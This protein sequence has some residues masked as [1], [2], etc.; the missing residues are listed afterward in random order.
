MSGFTTYRSLVDG[1]P[2]LTGGVPSGVIAMSSESEPPDGWTE[3]DGGG[4]TLDMRD[5]YIY[6]TNDEAEIGEQFGA[7]SA[8]SDGHA[9]EIFS[10]D[11]TGV[12]DGANSRS[13][14]TTPTNS[15]SLTVDLI[16]DS[17]TVAFVK[18]VES[19][20]TLEG[21]QAFTT[22]SDEDI[23]SAEGVEQLN[24]GSGQYDDRMPRGHDYDTDSVGD[25]FGSDE[26]GLNHDHSLQTIDIAGIDGTDIT[27]ITTESSDPGPVDIVPDIVYLNAVVFL[28]Q[29]NVSERQIF[30]WDGFLS[31]IPE[32]FSL[33]DGTGGT[34]DVIGRAIRIAGVQ[35]PL[36]TKDGQSPLDIPEHSHEESGPI[37]D[38]GGSGTLDGLEPGVNFGDESDTFGEVDAKQLP[39]APIQVVG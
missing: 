26:R 23:D 37:T 16:P 28:E 1:S 10:R 13:E 7:D 9:H 35:S 29:Q 25:T 18:A 17:V 39:V 14:D 31:D 19:G 4:D 8:T 21:I 24:D 20:A 33:A 36:D 34:D 5:T 32:P 30:L 12:E 3:C 22:S 6:S 2:Q 15:N 11:T 27:S 38:I